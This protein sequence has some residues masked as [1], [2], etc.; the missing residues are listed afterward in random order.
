MSDIVERLCNSCSCNFPDTPCGAEEECRAAFDAADEIA[1]LR[2]DNERLRAAL[3]V[4]TECQPHTYLDYLK[5]IARAALDGQPATGG[6][7]KY[8]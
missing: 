4:I 7:R 1:R 3:L 5:S 2:A 8:E 6:R